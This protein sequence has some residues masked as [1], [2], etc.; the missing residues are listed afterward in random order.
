M[1][2]LRDGGGHGGKSNLN[3]GCG[4]GGTDSDAVTA[5]WMRSRRDGCGHIYGGMELVTAVTD[6]GPA[7]SALACGALQCMTRRSV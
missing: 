6:G 5:V 3:D 4:H 7:V 2:S 1:L